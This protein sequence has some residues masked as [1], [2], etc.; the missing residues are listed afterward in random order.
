MTILKKPLL[1]KGTAFTEAERIK[2]GITGCLPPVYET[3][4]QQAERVF[5]QLDKLEDPLA[6]H[7][8]LGDLYHENRTL[9]Y[10]V[11]SK[12]ITEILPLIY[13]PTIGDAV[14]NYHLDYKT[15]EEALYIDAFNSE[16]LGTTLKHAASHP[17]SI[18]MMVITDGEGVLGLGDW[19]VNGVKIAVG[20]LA[21]YT[22]AAGIAPDRVLPIVIDAGTNNQE[23]IQS[24]RYL[25]NKKAR[26]SEEAY[27]HFIA[28]FV[29]QAKKIFPNAVFHWEDF[30]RNH[31][32]R[33]LE[34]Y[35]S[36]ICT[37]NDDIQ[38]TGAMVLAAALATTRVS[39]IPLKDQRIV[40]FGA[41]TAGIGI[42]EQLVSELMR[43]G[44]S[45]NEAKER[46]FLV[47]KEGLITDDLTH[48]T[49]G[50]QRFA[51]KA[52]LFSEKR[53]T[54]LAETIH[55]V[56]PHMLIGSSGVA[57][58]FSEDVV[59]TMAKH[60]DWPAILP[61]SNP[62]KLAEAKASDLIHWTEGRA[63]IVTG[64][65]T[66]PVTYND[67]TYYIGQANNAL[68]YPGLGLG[69]ILIRA[70]HIS[71]K[72]L[73]AASHAVCETVHLK[74]QGDILLPPIEQLRKTSYQVALAVAKQAIAEN[75]ANSS[76]NHLEKALEKLIWEPNYR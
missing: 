16:Q 49:T 37:F 52:S 1:N 28:H 40:V 59:R 23:L 61:L 36:K 3:I 54:T 20:K 2:H 53:P 67:T 19:G 13:T 34:T 30:G 29:E 12:N 68:L 72:M 21:V 9:Y 7:Y 31:A 41:G 50:Q 46:F 43:E 71:N 39:K 44:L 11:V 8:L 57:G 65:P 51:K 27:D 14:V 63:L 69:A 25:G 55:S 15:P 56:R 42:T 76:I 6:K 60:V 38:G 70:K 66:K 32:A 35:R 17:E 5:K 48:L 58:A 18:D 33:I 45:E 10:Y 64:S 62:T 26:L 73:L 74:K 24:S 75:L 4:A 22:V 47:D